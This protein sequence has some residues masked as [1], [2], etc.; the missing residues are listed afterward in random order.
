MR[1]DESDSAKDGEEE[2]WTSCSL[3]IQMHMFE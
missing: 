2:D 3:K 1:K